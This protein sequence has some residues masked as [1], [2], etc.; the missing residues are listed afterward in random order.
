MLHFRKLLHRCQ[1][2]RRYLL[3]KLS[4]S[5]FC[6]EFLCHGKG[7]RSKENAIGSIRW[8]VPEK[9]LY[10][11][12]NLANISYASR[13]LAN[14]VPY[15]VAMATGVGRGKCDWQHSMVHPTADKPTKLRNI[16]S[17]REKNNFT[18]NCVK[19]SEVV[20]T[21]P[22]QRRLHDDPPLTSEIVRRQKLHVLRITVAN[23]FT[24]TEHVQDL[25]VIIIIIII[26]I[27][28]CGFACN[29]RSF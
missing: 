15:F 14:F 16:Q 21:Y 6:P 24:V 17:W 26:I 18:L 28:R 27:L 3:H 20:F 11:Q 23:D 8:P 9:P 10:K 1:K 22:K 2:S 7:G 19:S 4:Y 29:L 25:T 12:K 13:V 5:Q